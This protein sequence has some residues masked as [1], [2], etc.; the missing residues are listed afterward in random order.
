MVETAEAGGALEAEAP[1][2]LKN[3]LKR[4]RR[5]FNGKHRSCGFVA[6]AGA[7]AGAAAAPCPRRAPLAW[8]R[9]DRA[10]GGSGYRWR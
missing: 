8:G 10:E 3:K 9:L 6:G 1:S 5:Q 2:R 4:S 7:G